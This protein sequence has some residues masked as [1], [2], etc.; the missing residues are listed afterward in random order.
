MT[1]TH[2]NM[3]GISAALNAARQPE[4]H[5]T[6]LLFC[7]NVN[8]HSPS[9]QEFKAPGMGWLKGQV[10]TCPNDESHGCNK[11][12]TEYMESE[13]RLIHRLQAQAGISLTGLGIHC[14]DI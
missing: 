3:P 6:I 13:Q 10:C 4:A 1:Q 7:Q 11:T 9:G 8:W 14:R 12:Q 2:L 5:L